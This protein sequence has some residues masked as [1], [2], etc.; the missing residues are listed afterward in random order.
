M[1]AFLFDAFYFR[2]PVLDSL[3]YQKVIKFDTEVTSG[4]VVSYFVEPMG[5]S[6]IVPHF[7]QVASSLCCSPYNC[8]HIFRSNVYETL[9]SNKFAYFVRA[10]LERT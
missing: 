3:G 6:P 2:L 4:I 1:N 9:C 10:V 8:C 7:V 5:E